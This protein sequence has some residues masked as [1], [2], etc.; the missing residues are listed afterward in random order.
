MKND[1]SSDGRCFWHARRFTM[2]THVKAAS[3][4]GLN[5]FGSCQGSSH[6]RSIWFKFQTDCA[7]FHEFYRESWYSFSCIGAAKFHLFLLRVP[8]GPEN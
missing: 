4:P 5:P 7:N 8:A 3:L 6:I 1:K 2:C